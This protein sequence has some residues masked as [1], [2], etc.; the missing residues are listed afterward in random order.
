MQKASER[1]GIITIAA[2]VNCGAAQQIYKATRIIVGTAKIKIVQIMIIGVV[3]VTK[4]SPLIVK[5]TIT[6]PATTKTQNNIIPI[7]G[8]IQQDIKANI[9]IMKGLKHIK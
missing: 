1:Q 7:I 6:G 5:Q 9:I 4:V 8:E 2:Q 3:R